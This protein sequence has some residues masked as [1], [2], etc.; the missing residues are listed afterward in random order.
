M[1]SAATATLDDSV[2]DRLL[3]ERIVV[4]AGEVDDPLANRVIA[5]LLLLAAEDP[6]AYSQ[7]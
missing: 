6:G 1:T 5:Q 7:V 2:F 4:L 3:R